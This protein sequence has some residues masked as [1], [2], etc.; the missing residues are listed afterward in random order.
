ME[1]RTQI[2]IKNRSSVASSVGHRPAAARAAAPA[3]TGASPLS[4]RRF[5]ASAKWPKPSPYMLLDT[6]HSDS[7]LRQTI[8][9]RTHD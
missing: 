8:T 7:R 6:R 5:L 3:H 9:Q 4:G 2:A 1:V